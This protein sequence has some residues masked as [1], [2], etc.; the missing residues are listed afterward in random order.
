MD[1][2]SLTPCV[3]NDFC[4]KQNRPQKHFYKIRETQQK[5]HFEVKRDSVSS[6]RMPISKEVLDVR[7]CLLRKSPN[8]S[9]VRWQ[10]D[11]PMVL[12]ARIRFRQGQVKSGQSTE[13]H[14]LVLAV[15]Q[16]HQTGLEVKKKLL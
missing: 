2:K 5:C 3:S 9:N 4:Q 15:L 11:D 1:C 16:M 8:S 12:A 13:L 7:F 14:T 6:K 10:E